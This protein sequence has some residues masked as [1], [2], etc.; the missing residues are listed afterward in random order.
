[1]PSLT[2]TPISLGCTRGSNFSS[3]ST[4]RWISSSVRVP[5]RVVVAM[6]LLLVALCEAWVTHEIAR[7]RCPRIPKG[8]PGV[9]GRCAACGNVRRVEEHASLDARRGGDDDERTAGGDEGPGLLAPHDAG[10]GGQP[11]RVPR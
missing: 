4:S 5:A 8:C 6:A 9:H 10:S 2:V 11:A 7:A 3:L 1:M